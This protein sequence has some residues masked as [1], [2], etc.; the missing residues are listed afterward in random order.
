MLLLVGALVGLLA[1]PMAS[2]GTGGTDRPFTATL[3]GVATFVVPQG[4]P[5]NCQAFTSVGDAMGQV[6]HLGLVTYHST[7]LPYDVANHLD[8]H[9]TLT[10]ANGD[11]LYGVYD[12]VL[13]GSGPL[14]VTFTG[15]TGRPADASGTADES[16]ETIPQHKPMPPCVPETDAFG[17][18][19][20]D[21]PWPWSGTMTGTI[22]Y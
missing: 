17:C 2:A 12:Y 6:T 9:M 8:G 18:L 5:P 7:H 13:G 10:A 21:V 4:C 22:S 11:E 14:V 15:G 3:S 19:N 16:F 1:V 20:P